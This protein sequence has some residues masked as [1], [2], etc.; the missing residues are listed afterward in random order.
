MK[1][2]LQYIVSLLLVIYITFFSQ[3]LKAQCF[4]YSNLQDSN[5]VTCYYGSFY[6]PYDSIGIKPG[7]HTV[8][9]NINETD[10]LTNNQLTC[11]PF[12]DTVSVKLGDSINNGAT[13]EAI[14]Y[15]IHIDTNNYSLLFIKY[16]IVLHDYGHDAEHQPRFI[17]QILDTLG[18]LIFPICGEVNFNAGD[19]TQWNICSSGEF[20]NVN[21]KNW[22]TLGFDVSQFH[23]R[24]I[25]IRLT[26][27]DCAFSWDF[28]YAYF[29]MGCGKKE[30]KVMTC[31]V[32]S[33]TLTAPPNFNYK[34]YNTETPYV[35]ISTNQ[36]ITVPISGENYACE[37]LFKIN[38][39]CK[40]TLSAKAQAVFPIAKFDYHPQ[41]SENCRYKVTFENLSSTSIDGVTPN[42]S[43][44][45]CDHYK[46]YFHDGF[47]SSE[48]DPIK[49]YNEK[50]SYPVKLVAYLIG[51]ICS[52]TIDID[53][54]IG[55][56]DSSLTI[57][58]DTIICKGGQ[59]TLTA[60]NDRK[61]YLWN[62][63]DTTQ[64]I[65]VSLEKTNLYSV[66]TIDYFGCKEIKFQMVHVMPLYIDTIYEEICEGDMFLMFGFTQY[67]PGFY[68]HTFHSIYGCDSIRNLSLS[69]VS[70]PI[71]YLENE[72][73][74]EEYP[75][76]LDATCNDCIRYNWNTGDTVPIIT[77]NQSGYYY[78]SAD[79]KC[80]KVYG[81][82]NIL[83]PEIIIYFPN[84]FTPQK[85]TNNI[86]LPKLNRS[87]DVVIESFVVYN[88]WGT[89]LFSTNEKDK[90]WD[91]KYEGR[92]CYSDTYIW[93]L[94]YKTIYSG[95]RLFEKTGEVY[96]I[97]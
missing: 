79:Y 32:S 30:L 67:L 62:T 1:T 16:A 82:T 68:T 92:E 83:D 8:K 77:V 69:F 41:K 64:S 25:V 80:G 42:T 4:D 66:S 9:H 43:D 72:I 85:N 28:G 35:T 47:V 74:V 3:E 65:T 7:R 89:K 2:I 10:P 26:T 36:T 49:Y 50:G 22:T 6:Y 73:Q 56:L 45:Q 94:I 31:G 40:F 24:T 71:F 48:K 81:S 84:A 53:V 86:F 37:C 91:G 54:V 12:G 18:H 5:L 52:D 14:T 46:W 51:G 61:S 27:Y 58:G 57:T 87:E 55:D 63:Q 93:R 78:V 15:K 33:A 88:K 59:T 20:Y 70:A 97:K 76:T 75:I 23:D 17:I 60:S 90:G 39:M 29:T 34:W 44:V 19:T 38:A 13:A 96:L 11:I 21:W 95:N